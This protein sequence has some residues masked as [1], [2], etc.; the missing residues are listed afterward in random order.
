MFLALYKVLN[1]EI[2]ELLASRKEM[3][4]GEINQLRYL[5]QVKMIT[6]KQ[7]LT[8]K[9]LSFFKYLLFKFHVYIF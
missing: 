1:T 8:S 4:N 7:M 3:R 2:N 9:I 6:N 5:F